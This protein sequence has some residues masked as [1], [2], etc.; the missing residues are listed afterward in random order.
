MSSLDRLVYEKKYWNQGY[1]NV[2]GG[3]ECGLGCLAGPMCCAGV[4]IEPFS[5][6][7]E[8][9]KVR[10]SKILTQSQRETLYEEIINCPKI[11]YMI[12]FGSVEE[13]DTY[14]IL[15]CTLRHVINVAY[16][17][18]ADCLLYDGNKSPSMKHHNPE[19][20]PDINKFK[21][22]INNT[23]TIVKGDNL[24]LSIAAASI[25]AKVTRDRFMEQLGKSNESYL[26]Y[27]WIENHGYPSTDHRLALRDYGPCEH[28]RKTYK[29]TPPSEKQIEMHLKKQNQEPKANAVRNK[30]RKTNEQ[31][32]NN[33]SSS[34]SQNANENANVESEAIR[35]KKKRITKKQQK[36]ENLFS[37]NDNQNQTINNNNI[38][39]DQNKKNECNDFISSTTST[40][41]GQNTN[42]IEQIVSNQLREKFQILFSNEKNKNI[43]SDYEN[44]YLQ[45]YLAGMFNRTIHLENIDNAKK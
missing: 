13:I 7:S 37:A 38:L 16:Q 25:L 20:Q 43:Y 19:T 4:I 9:P 26:K 44:G 24:S 29:W 6:E 27:N 36:I 11:K 28:H 12:E 40:N 35:V 30:K 34:E 33:N 14:N 8:L 39:I 2:I 31:I 22:I 23:E 3:D 10:D 42:E 18:N 21:K 32:E 45:G 1:L 41:S 15:H 17:M 5:T